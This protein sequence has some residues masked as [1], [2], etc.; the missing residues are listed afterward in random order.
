M[1]Q[2]DYIIVGCGLAGIAFS[3]QLIAKK[4]SFVVFDNQS[5]QS[6]VVAGGLYNPVVLKRFTSVWKSKE[7]LNLALP[8]YK[9]IEEKLHITIDNKIPVYRRFTSLEEQ[10]NWFL[11]SDNVL[12]AEHLSPKIIK[13][14][15][16]HI[17]AE[18]GFGKVLN[19]G[20]I[21]TNVL[22]QSYKKYLFEN[23]QLIEEAFN[24]NE[25]QK[26]DNGFLYQKYSTTHIVFAEGFGL[27]QNPF[28]NYLPIKESKGELL[29][30]HAPDLKI[31]FVL[32]SSVFVLP[33]GNDLYHIG[34]T[35]NW[36]DKTNNITKEGREE[37]LNKLK[38]FLV[39]DFE[40][41]NQV[42]GI[43]PTVKD[44]RPLVG[45]HPEMNNMYVL[46]GLGTRGVMIGP[47]VAKQLFNY[48]ENNSELNPEINI[49]RFSS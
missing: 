45:K 5:Q 10:N 33:L 18:Y 38:T 6:S 32:K 43:R 7:Q 9:Q 20:R 46:N 44:R 3:E 14:D 16:P 28:F 29:T 37:L 41:V 34:A 36:T 27:K 8:M 40:V 23:K 2:V 13:N 30:I 22:N 26:I 31:D 48:I 25:L 21:Q 12:L 17:Q 49:N 35:Y 47:Y 4:K 42:A 19:T 15:N 11:A 24:Y 39:C 1:K